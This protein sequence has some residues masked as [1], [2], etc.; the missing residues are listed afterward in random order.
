MDIVCVTLFGQATSESRDCLFTNDA[1]VEVRDDDE[2]LI[3]SHLD[4]EE[5]TF[6]C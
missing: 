3:S 6:A 2:Q 1:S 4:W 5:L